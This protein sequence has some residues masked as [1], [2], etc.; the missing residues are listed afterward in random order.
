MLLDAMSTLGMN[1]AAEVAVVALA[2][3]GDKPAFEELVRRRQSAVRNLLRR[4]C[5]DHALADDLSQQAFIQAWKTLPSLQSPA[6]FGGWLRQIA[7]NMWLQHARGAKQSSSIEEAD[8][9]VP[10]MLET[11]GERIDLDQALMQLST[12]VRLC[13]VLAHAEGM[14]HG[15]VASTTG[16][17]LGTVKSH[18]TRGTAKLRELLQAYEYTKQVNET[19]KSS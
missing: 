7:V 3:L 12:G 5:R 8:L 1:N 18:I 17:P 11:H 4:L 16:L 2:K 15:E 9:P 10:S 13:I 19:S 14:S 6:A